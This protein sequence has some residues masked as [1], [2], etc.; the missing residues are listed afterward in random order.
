MGTIGGFADGITLTLGPDRLT[1]PAGAN[2]SAF[3]VGYE[4]SSGVVVSNASAESTASRPLLFTPV[5]V[6]N[7]ETVVWY[8]YGRFDTTGLTEGLQYL[9]PD[10]AGQFTSTRPS[11][12]G[13]I[14]RICGHAPSS[15]VFEF[16]P[17]HSWVE[18]V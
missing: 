6:N 12:S 3:T 10:N 5:A 4:T 9:D 13:D 1:L 14:V 11:D 17:D 16:D 2:F 18:L 7:G 8:K 15:T